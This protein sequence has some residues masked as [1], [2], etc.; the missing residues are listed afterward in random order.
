MAFVSKSPMS[1]WTPHSSWT[2]LSL[3]VNLCH[4]S[5][6]RTIG[7]FITG[8]NH[9][10]HDL[11]FQ[12]FVSLLWRSTYLCKLGVI[13]LCDFVLGLGLNLFIRWL[14]AAPKYWKR[15]LIFKWLVWTYIQSTDWIWCLEI[16]YMGWH[17]QTSAGPKWPKSCYLLQ[18]SQ[19]KIC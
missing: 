18:K 11:L 16:N 4:C 3:L 5:C 8:A 14:I 19:C 2:S 7:D 12:Y 15:T 1:S 13:C 17:K 9:H 6:N 10:P